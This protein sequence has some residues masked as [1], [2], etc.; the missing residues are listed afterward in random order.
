MIDN[1]PKRTDAIYQEI[2][3]YED[4]EYTNCIAYQM[5]IRNDRVVKIMKILKEIS[6][7]RNKNSPRS[8]KSSTL[9]RNKKFP[10]FE[11]KM[12]EKQLIYN[13]EKKFGINYY[14]MSE[15]KSF[16]GLIQRCT[17]LYAEFKNDCFEMS[18]NIMLGKKIMHNPSANFV[19][20]DSYLIEQI[21][22]SKK[23]KGK[24]TSNFKYQLKLDNMMNMILSLN[25]HLP[26][27]E[28]IAYLSKI[29][30]D[31]D[32]DYS[33]IKS[34][35]ELIGQKLDK[36]EKITSK[37]LPQDKNRRK[38]AMADAFYIYDIWKILEQDYEEKTV[39]LKA[40]QKEEI[41]AIEQNKNYDKD[42]KKSRIYETKQ[43]Y[44]DELRNY[45]KVSLKTEIASQLNVSIDTVDKLHSLMIKYIDNLKY[46]E[47]ITG[48]TN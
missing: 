19:R 44:E 43:K 27:E 32:K 4:Y 25:F 1:L 31:F 36:A 34:P 29:K 42:D 3:S 40:K 16:F 13:L 33:I 48:I 7:I 23:D 45:T 20:K 12:L 9:F 38:K 30:D 14:Y 28:L 5:A 35:L 10:L 6:N 17:P 8:K 22:N 15:E 18:K 2:E 47:L 21:Y 11:N 37:A 26:K 41:K 46:K 24:I 39:E